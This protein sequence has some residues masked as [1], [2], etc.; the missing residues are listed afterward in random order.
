MRT[1]GVAAIAVLAL[2][3][4]ILQA[5]APAGTDWQRLSNIS[6]SYGSLF[7]AAALMGVAVSLA[8]QSRQTA[9]ANEE[10]QRASHR[11][12][13]VMALNDP[14]LMVCW[15]PPS[16]EMTPVEAKQIGFA[17]LIISN[18]SADYSLKRFNDDALRVRLE[19][20]FRGEIAR[21]HW[22]VGGLGWRRFAEALGDSRGIRF[23]T[24]IDEAYAQAV[25][26]GP[27]RSS[28]SYY[29]PG[30]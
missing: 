1:T 25:S 14:E 13:V 12:L 10:A 21:K 2:A 19:V 6:Q 11:Q 5:A 3:P 29:R 4:L 17:N 18:W 20:H 24:L 26:A 9:T 8:H 27:P 7:S 15:E 22:Q 23:V 16:I 30:R 28:S